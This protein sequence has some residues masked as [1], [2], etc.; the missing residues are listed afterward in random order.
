M[1]DINDKFYEQEKGEF[2][3]GENMKLAHILCY[4]IDNPK[5]TF[6]FIEK[7]TDKKLIYYLN[8]FMK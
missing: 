3:T 2:K 7:I 5:F 1:M 4:D 8:T 6:R